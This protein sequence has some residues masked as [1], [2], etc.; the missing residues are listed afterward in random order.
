M[1]FSVDASGKATVTQ[2]TV[3]DGN[4]INAFLFTSNPAGTGGNG[5][6][7]FPGNASGPQNAE[8]D[9]IS[10]GADAGI[11]FRAKGNPPVP[12]GIHS[13]S[14][15]SAKIA[16]YAKNDESRHVK[17]AAPDVI[18]SAYNLTFPAT[19]GN[20]GDTFQLDANRNLSFVPLTSPNFQYIPHSAVTLVSGNV[21]HIALTS[22]PTVTYSEGLKL[23]FF[24]E[25]NNDAINPLTITVDGNVGAVKITSGG[26]LIA[27][28]ANSVVNG[29]YYEITADNAVGWI[30]K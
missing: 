9:A 5:I 15:A 10:T 18:T 20:V 19:I 13:T 11:S 27:V 4:N 26:A 23:G 28:P 3:V 14:S 6:K 29:G 1:T 2:L 16:L 25:A 17:L 12:F 21:N 22:N 24:A 7:F 30:L 8:F